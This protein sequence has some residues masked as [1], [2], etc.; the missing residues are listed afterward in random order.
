MEENL[1]KSAEGGFD[2][3]EFLMED[4]A[5]RDLMVPLCDKYNLKGLRNACSRLP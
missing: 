4:K 2:G 3:V 5:H 1:A